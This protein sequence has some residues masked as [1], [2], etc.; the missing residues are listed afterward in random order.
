M[1]GFALRMDMFGAGLDAGAIGPGSGATPGMAGGVN[2]LG[3][4]EARAGRSRAPASSDVIRMSF[5]VLIGA[6]FPCLRD[7]R[8]LVVGD[9]GLAARRRE[10]DDDVGVTE[11]I[12]L[13]DVPEVRPEPDLVA[14]RAVRAP[15]QDDARNAGYGVVRIGDVVHRQDPAGG[16]VEAPRAQDELLAPLEYV[17]LRAADR[18]RRRPGGARAVDAV[19]VDA[20]V[21]LGA[22]EAVRRRPTARRILRRRRDRQLRGCDGHL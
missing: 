17:G 9:S 10:A 6:R 3:S 19:D 4:A 7:D 2:G 14:G 13:G 15:V 8:D 11:W 18:P 20:E 16:E 1:S 21:E 5:L 22:G 12:V